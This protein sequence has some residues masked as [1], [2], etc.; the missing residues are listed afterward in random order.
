MQKKLDPN[1]VARVVM[2]VLGNMDHGGPY[3]AY[4]AIK[5]GRYEE[6]KHAIGTKKYNIQNFVKDEYGEA[7][8]SGEG[9]LPPQAVTKEVA[10]LFNVPIKQLFADIDPLD[11][12]ARGIKKLEENDNDK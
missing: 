11:A 3:W 12:I 9:A 2:L 6:F 5:P 10:A 4:V 1:D 7:V 8:V